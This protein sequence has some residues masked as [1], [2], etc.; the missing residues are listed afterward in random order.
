MLVDL[1]RDLLFPPRC[2]A[3]GDDAPAAAGLCPPCAQTLV[4]LGPACPRCAEPRAEP[5]SVTCR[6]CRRDPLPMTGIVA[7]WRY[8]GA[9]ADALR[10]LKFAGQA[11]LARTLAPLVGPYLAAT[12]RLAEIDVIVPVPLHWWRRARRGFDQ[13]ALL[14]GTACRHAVIA[15]PISHAL[16]RRRRTRPQSAL[17]AAERGA[18]VAGAFGITPTTR[19]PRLAG[20]RVLVFDDIVT[21]GATMAAAAR[22]LTAAG[23]AEVLGFAVARAEP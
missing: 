10:A 7:P 9:L 18:N 4:V 21:T 11:H 6:R 5:P 23:A 20:R 17:P 1:V 13:A 16:R 2:A 19:G 14:A 15:T 22:A 3:C 8:G 12:C